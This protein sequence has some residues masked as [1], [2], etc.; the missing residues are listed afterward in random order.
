[1]KDRTTTRASRRAILKTGAL[2][3]LSA[4]AGGSAG[5]NPLNIFGQDA[6][7]PPYDLLGFKTYREYKRHCKMNGITPAVVKPDPDNPSIVRE[8]R[9]CME[10]GHCDGACEAQKISHWYKKSDLKPEIKHLCMHC[11]QCIADCRFNSM[12]EKLHFPALAR[13]MA[14]RDAAVESDATSKQIFVAATAPAVRVAV[15]ELFGLAPGEVLQEHMVGALKKL[16]FDYVLDVTFG[17][18]LTTMEEARELQ[19]RLDS[20]VPG[21]MFTSCCPAWVTFVETFF[22]ELIPNLSTTRSPILLQ[23]A[24]VK[25]RFAQEKGLDPA[26]ITYVAVAPCVAKKYEAIRPE[27]DAAARF[28]KN[29]GE[30]RDLDYVLTTRE[31][32]SWFAYAQIDPSKE[33]PR[34]YDALL[35]TGSGSGKGF[36]ST[37]GV[38]RAVVRQFW[39]NVVGTEPSAELFELKEVDGISGLRETTIEVGKYKL[40]IAVLCG[41]GVARELLESGKLDYDLVEVMACPTG[42]VGGGGQPKTL[43]GRKATDEMRQGRAEGLRKLDRE[44]TFRVAGDNPEIQSFYRD[45]V[46]PG[47]A[48]LRKTLLHTGYE[49]RDVWRS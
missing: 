45:F 49:K 33:T 13:A 8:S 23:G 24:A 1:M 31:V 18:D 37:G 22:P 4:F 48:E 9:N 39:K 5:L 10:C 26:D 44:E 25:T 16:G 38:T 3:A 43:E 15:G 32:G 36:G 12:H 41:L 2:G 28:W 20:G 34:E 30:F 27:H 35:G 29:K 19:E 21:P 40:R 17:A 46:E 7:G 6:S 47:G 42:C 14:K 11:G